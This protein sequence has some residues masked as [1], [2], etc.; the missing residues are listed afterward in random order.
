MLN[1]VVSV[2]Y[3]A[4]RIYSKSMMLQYLTDSLTHEENTSEINPMV[5]I[6]VPR[7]TFHHLD[8]YQGLDIF[9]E[10]GSKCTQLILADQSRVVQFVHHLGLLSGLERN[11]SINSGCRLSSDRDKRLYRSKFAS[12]IFNKL[13]SPALL[14]D[15]IVI[16]LASCLLGLQSAKSA[17]IAVS[18]YGYTRAEHVVTLQ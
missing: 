6:H 13:V 14:C 2:I 1:I 8:L 7:L 9:I 5:K 4:Q 15:F 17:C 18:G 11:I 12:F 10:H 3:L 16:F